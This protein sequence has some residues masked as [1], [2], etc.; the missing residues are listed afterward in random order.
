[1]SVVTGDQLQAQHQVRL[2]DLQLTTPNFTVDSAGANNNNIDIRGIGLPGIGATAGVTPGVAILRDGLL[3]DESVG[4]STTNPMYDIQSVTV[5]KGP[6]G[7]FIGASAIG[8]AVQINSRDPVLGTGLSGYIEGLIGNYSDLKLDGALNFPIAD[9][10]AMRIAFNVEGRGSFYKDIGAYAPG[11]VGSNQTVSDPGNQNDRDFRVGLLWAP[12]DSLQ[13][14]AKI[15]N[16][17]SVIDG[18]GEN[19]NPATFINPVTGVVTHAPYYQ[20]YTGKPFLINSAVLVAKYHQVLQTNLLQVTYT[21]PDKVQLRSLSG[22]QNVST[23]GYTQF[24]APVSENTGFSIAGVAPNPYWQQ[25]FLAISPASWRVSYIAGAFWFHRATSQDNNSANYAPPYSILNPQVNNTI[26]GPYTSVQRMVGLFGQLSWQ[27]NPTLQLQVG[28]RENWD[29]NY[30]F[31]IYQTVIPS[32]PAPVAPVHVLHYNLGHYSDSV[33]T[34]KVGLN[35][36]PAAG[37]LFYAFVAR[38]YKSGGVST[39]GPNFG[40]E[41]VN[42]YE[43]GWKG[44]VLSGHLQADI[45]GF[46]MNYTDMQESVFNP[47]SAGTQLINIPGGS[48]IDGVEAS[49]QARAGRFGANVAFAYTHSALGTLRLVDSGYIPATAA[50]LPQCEGGAAPPSC[51]DYSPFYVT[52]SGE[53]NNLSPKFSGSAGLN[54]NF[55]LGEDVLTPE[56]DLQYVGAQYASLFQQNDYY[57][58]RAHGVI[59]ASLTYDSGPWTV[60]AYGKNLTNKIYEVGNNGNLVFYGD[61]RQYGLRFSRSF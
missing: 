42:D 5:L 43:L 31:G 6:Q 29:N 20:Y 9:T 25:E 22:F 15:G 60:A 19:I 54:Y 24:G 11:N 49:L 41:H 58:M 45:G 4:A 33:P 39:S 13:V 21:L 16:D 38:G 48:T 12:N 52:V 17:D 28:G 32:P 37:Q 3:D 46:Y 44:T 30:N 1:M 55:A 61:P 53:P 2:I 14:L 34:G 57:L 59:G 40:P 36:T 18:S 23:I 26:T 47:A 27:I 50:G 8:G 7:T 10:F 56:L 35:W 51:F